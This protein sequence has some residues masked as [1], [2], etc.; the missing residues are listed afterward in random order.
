ALSLWVIMGILTQGNRKALPIALVLGVALAAIDSTASHA[1]SSSLLWLAVLATTLHIAAMGAWTGGG[2]ALLVLWRH[3]AL[4][5]R[6]RE[7][8]ARFSFL[9]AVSV[10]ELVITGLV[11]AGLHLTSPADLLITSYGRV[12]TIKVVALLLPLLF[13]AL[14]LRAPL[15][16]RGNWWRLELLALL[17]IL[18]LA[19][20]LVSL[21]APR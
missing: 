6:R 15:S 5:A 2:I 3:T 9:A 4:K 11:L 1:I 19:A 13:V 7:L 17:G 18:T 8:L 10:A 12:L 20:T 21:P 14:S 16:S